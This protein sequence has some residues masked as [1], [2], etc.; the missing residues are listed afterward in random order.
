M[1]VRVEVGVRGRAL[2]TWPSVLSHRGSTRATRPSPHNHAP[3]RTS[4]RRQRRCRLHY[5]SGGTFFCPMLSTRRPRWI[6]NLDFCAV[7]GGALAPGAQWTC[8]LH[9]GPTA[10]Q[11]LDR[12]SGGLQKLSHRARLWKADVSNVLPTPVWSFQGRPGLQS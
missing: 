9:L 3:Q 8:R 6:G 2:T 5:H 12:V 10:R 11:E 7:F 4:R 1:D